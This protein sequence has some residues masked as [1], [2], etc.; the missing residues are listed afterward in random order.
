MVNCHH[1]I[2]KDNY[3]QYTVPG[4]RCVPKLSKA[5]APPTLAAGRILGRMAVS[6]RALQPVRQL[7]PWAVGVAALGALFFGM[8]AAVARSGEWAA[9][10]M[11]PPMYPGSVR[12][13]YLRNVKTGYVQEV[14]TYETPDEV[15]QVIDYFSE[16]F[17]PAAADGTMYTATRFGRSPLNVAD[18][19][20]LG[21]TVRP[22]ASVTVQSVASRAVTQIRVI[23]IWPEVRR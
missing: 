12:V 9:R 22:K 11:A 6:R 1:K 10:L 18:Y 14:S 5:A 13:E 4:L 15:R 23:M 16:R 2:V 8:Q 7:L 20:G 17:I 3:S 19:I 21:P